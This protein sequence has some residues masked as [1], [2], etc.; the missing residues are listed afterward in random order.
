MIFLEFCVC[1]L[2]MTTTDGCHNKPKKSP[3][4]E[5]WTLYDS[6]DEKFLLNKT[7]FVAIKKSVEYLCKRGDTLKLRTRLELIPQAPHIWSIKDSKG[8]DPCVGQCNSVNTTVDIS[9]RYHD[10][11]KSD[12]MSIIYV[13]RNCN[14]VY[15]SP[16]TEAVSCA[17]SSVRKL[18]RSCLRC[19]GK[20]FIFEKCNAASFKEK[21]CSGPQTKTEI[22][23][24]SWSN[25]L[26]GNCSAVTCDATGERTRTRSCLF[27]DGSEAA[28][29]QKCSSEPASVT[30]V[31]KLNHVVSNDSGRLTFCDPTW[32]AWSA[33]SCTATRCNSIGKRKKTRKCLNH[34]NIEVDNTRLCS[35]Q[36]A[37]MTEKCISNYFILKN[38]TV[39]RSCQPSWSAW[40]ASQCSATTCNE[41]GKRMKKRKCLY[42][43]GSDV[44]DTQLCSGHPEVTTE[45]CF[46][47]DI[48]CSLPESKLSLEV[49]IGVG[50]GSGVM[51]LCLVSV[52]FWSIKKVLRSPKPTPDIEHHIYSEIDDVCKRSTL[53]KRFKK[54]FQKSRIFSIT[55]RSNILYVNDDQKTNTEKKSYFDV[56]SETA[57]NYNR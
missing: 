40:V 31:C 56:Y 57:Q 15:W 33:T 49:W 6:M 21:Y 19:D 34:R 46:A 50:V 29:T 17:F 16:W 53:A 55:S 47:S 12:T 3:K 2:M 54:T 45:S 1:V 48:D 30:D 22:C 25:W 37:I 27:N 35:N 5:I 28:D 26:E 11:P 51:I 44:N 42:G 8:L 4:P 9:Y 13:D 10:S 43:D 38:S 7:L 23:V 39:K 32:S 36:S 18:R 24:P 20:E 14:K 52:I 41:E